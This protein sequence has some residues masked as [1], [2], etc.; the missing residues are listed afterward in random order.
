MFLCWQL[1]SAALTEEMVS[2]RKPG[3]TPMVTS[4]ALSFANPSP[5]GHVQHGSNLP[6]YWGEFWGQHLAPLS[7]LSPQ[8][9]FGEHR[10]HTRL[11]KGSSWQSS[12]LPML[13][14]SCQPLRVVPGGRYYFYSKTHFSLIISVLHLEN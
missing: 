13:G 11:V 12:M 3:G 5:G 1:A 7:A 2:C 9:P 4:P 10:S 8:S 6:F 14:F